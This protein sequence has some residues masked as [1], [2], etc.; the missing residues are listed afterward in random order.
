[1]KKLLIIAGGIIGAAVDM[2][3]GA[4]YVYPNVFTNPYQ[5]Q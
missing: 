5:C 2:G 3:T 4:A 1:M